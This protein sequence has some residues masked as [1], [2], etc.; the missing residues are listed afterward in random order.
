MQSILTS[1]ASARRREHSCSSA[2]ADT[3][4]APDTPDTPNAFKIPN[5]PNNCLGSR[6]GV[7]KTMQSKAEQS[8][9]QSNA[10]Q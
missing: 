10:K 2:A 3:P 6:A 4:N 9:K 1:G 5:T 7:I 8:E